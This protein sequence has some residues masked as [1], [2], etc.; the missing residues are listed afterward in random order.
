M[1]EQLLNIVRIQN[2]QTI[3]FEKILRFQISLDGPNHK[4]NQW[5]TGENGIIGCQSK[6]KIKFHAE[7]LLKKWDIHINRIQYSI[8]I[9]LLLFNISN[10]KRFFG[11][12]YSLHLALQKEFGG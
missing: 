2:P 3:F 5:T 9:L 1:T 4:I 10:S 11:V 7:R 6:E 12:G 8:H